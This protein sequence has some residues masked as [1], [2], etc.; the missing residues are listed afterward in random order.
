MNSEVLKKIR[1]SKGDRCRLVDVPDGLFDLPSEIEVVSG[2]K[3]ASN[4]L[5]YSRSLFDLSS[6]LKK[7]AKFLSQ[8]VN[9]T[10]VMPKS[11]QISSVSKLSH[12]DVLTNIGFRRIATFSF[13]DEHQAIRFYYCQSLGESNDIS[14]DELAKHSQ[15]LRSRYTSIN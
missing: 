8:R 3:R 5:A 14:I 15:A 4:V 1:L 11:V 12:F 9:L 10:V 2:R 13:D 7:S 6:V